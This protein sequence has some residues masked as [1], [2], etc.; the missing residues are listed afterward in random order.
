M[1]SDLGWRLDAI[2]KEFFKSINLENI[3]LRTKVDVDFFKKYGLTAPF[4]KGIV[5]QVLNNMLTMFIRNYA[6]ENSFELP[7]KEYFSDE[8]I[9]FIIENYSK[10]TAL[11]Q[12]Q[13]EQL[14]NK[15]R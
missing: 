6:N 11:P 2:Y 1:D 9:L 4:Q 3:E 15:N 10:Y 7:D 8:E 5:E 13:I 14:K 12:E